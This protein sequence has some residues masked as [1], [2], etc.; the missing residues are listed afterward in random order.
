[1]ANENSR[2]RRTQRAGTFNKLQRFDLQN[3]PSRQSRVTDPTDD[4]QSKNQTIEAWPE[5]GYQSD[6]QKNSGKSHQG[7]D[8]QHRYK[9]VQ[10]TTYKTCTSAYQ[11]AGHHGEQNNGRPY[12][13]TDASTH[14]DARKNITA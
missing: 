1:M 2:P 7:V 6:R 11:N 4:G 12:S 13:H 5:E 8:D 10:L 9:S 3:L 14:E